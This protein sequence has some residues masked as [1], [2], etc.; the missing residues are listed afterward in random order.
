MRDTRQ[1][2]QSH[3]RHQN[4]NN[5]LMQV[6]ATCRNPDKA[7]E[8]ADLLKKLGQPEA[9]ALDITDDGSIEALKN[10]VTTEYGKIDVLVNNA[11]K[12]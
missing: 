5:F 7:A 11:G 4:V 3:H 6:L 1:V 9:L 8:L 12:V 10:K 2:T